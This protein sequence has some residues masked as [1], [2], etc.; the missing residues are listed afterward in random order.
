M[1]F[2][3]EY[4]KDCIELFN[5]RIVDIE[6][7]TFMR[8]LKR[9]KPAIPAFIKLAEVGRPMAGLCQL[10]P[11]ESFLASLTLLLALL[12]NLIT[13]LMKEL[14]GWSLEMVTQHQ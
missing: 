5:G 1:G 4:G 7:K 13:F 10:A 6:M 11:A 2:I 14:Y 8:R 3:E 12:V 9:V